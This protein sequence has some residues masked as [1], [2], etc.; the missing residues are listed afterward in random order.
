[1]EH[2]F[3][4]L[5]TYYDQEDQL[6]TCIESIRKFYPNNPI[7]LSEESD[8]IPTELKVD[9]HIF[10]NM[11]QDSWA[12]ACRGLMLNC[13]TDI[14]VFIEH[15]CVLM[16]PIDDLVNKLNEFDLIGVEEV[17]PDLRNSPGYANQ[18]FFILNVKKFIDTHGIDAIKVTVKDEMKSLKNIESAYGISQHSPKIFWLPVKNSGYG[19]GTYYGDYV[20]HMWYGSYRRRNVASDGVDTNWLDTEVY[21]FIKDFNDKS[22]TNNSI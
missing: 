12:G 21:R 2:K 22:S 20:H 13:P 16:K 10:H 7:I 6:K 11:K 9:K 14:G 17:I 4:F 15:D 1:M 3:S 5:I 19:H 18:N 8:E